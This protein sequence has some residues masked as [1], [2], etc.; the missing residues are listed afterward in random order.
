MLAMCA[1][2]LAPPNDP[3]LPLVAQPGAG[4]YLSVYLSSP[5]ARLP[6]RDVMRLGDNKSD[7]NLETMT[8]G[9]FSTC[10]PKMR[11]SIAA[12]GIEEIF[13]LANLHGGEGRALVGMYE[14]GWQVEVEKGD[15]AFAA[16]SG[17]FIEPIPCRQFAVR[18][19]T[20][21]RRRFGSTRWSATLRRRSSVRSCMLPRIGLRT[22]LPRST[23]SSG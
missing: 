4:A 23:A 12:R 21:Y 13:F 17:K 15:I 1:A 22:T 20:P 7:P 18:R 2:S 9:L 8:Y 14:L 5:F 11:V 10:E 19:E 3:W 16:K 6:I